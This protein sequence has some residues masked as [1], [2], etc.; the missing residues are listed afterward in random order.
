MDGGKGGGRR[1]RLRIVRPAL[2]LGAKMLLIDLCKIPVWWSLATVGAILAA[3]VV[4]SLATPRTP[5]H[6]PLEQ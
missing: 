1:P 6:K 2:E 5:E 3:S 4:A